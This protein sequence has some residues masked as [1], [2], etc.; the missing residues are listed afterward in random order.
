M[1]SPLRTTPSWWS[2][3]PCLPNA[4]SLPR[5]LHLWC[6]QEPIPSRCP[7]CG[8]GA[9][10]AWFEPTPP[11]WPRSR[12]KSGRMTRSRSSRCE[13]TCVPMARSTSA[14][15]AK[16]PG[17][18]RPS[19][20]RGWSRATRTTPACWRTPGWCGAAMVMSTWSCRPRAKSPWGSTAWARWLGCRR[21]A[22]IASSP[23]ASSSWMWASRTSSPCSPRD[24]RT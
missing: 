16:G 8:A 5:T 24:L 4:D 7:S 19:S 13:Q 3:K 17:P 22:V 18:W 21:G 23:R 2:M 15:P 9:S 14:R 10:R 6:A 1:G 12:S 20:G 11:R